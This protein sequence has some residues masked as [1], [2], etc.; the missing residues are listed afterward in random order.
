MIKVFIAV[1]L[2]VI[3]FKVLNIPHR[4]RK[5]EVIAGMSLI[6]TFILNTIVLIV[7]G[8]VEVFISRGLP[9]F[10]CSLGMITQIY[11]LLK[12]KEPDVFFKNANAIAILGSIMAIFFSSILN[13]NF[14]EYLVSVFSH[15]IFL[16][17]SVYSI[18]VRN[19]RLKKNE[20]KTC[21]KILC[22]WNI[23]IFIINIFMKTNYSFVSQS[24]FA[25]YVNPIIVLI[26]NTMLFIIFYFIDYKYL[27][28]IKIRR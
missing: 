14:M 24:P 23:F 12:D 19:I 3:I 18:W 13:N 17:I 6:V 2:F 20:Y 1:I 5:F 9:L 4:N 15:T 11:Y 22:A 25:F 16:M 26:C 21:I 28:M 8:G 7:T 27:S 10:Q